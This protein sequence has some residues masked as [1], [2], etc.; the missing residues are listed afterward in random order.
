MV[1]WN[2]TPESPCFT[3]VIEPVVYESHDGQFYVQLPICNAE[4]MTIHK[5]VGSNLDAVVIDCF[6]GFFAEHQLWDYD[7]FA[8]PSRIPYAIAKF[9][10]K[11]FRLPFEEEV[12]PVRQ[13]CFLIQNR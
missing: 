12:W 4:A 13:V 9:R 10:H 7:T 5:A 1:L 11:S 8:R 3:T 2:Q 6:G